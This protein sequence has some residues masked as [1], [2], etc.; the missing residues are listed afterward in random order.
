M[1]SSNWNSREIK[2]QKLGV[3]LSCCQSSVRSNHSILKEIQSTT[4]HIRKINQDKYNFLVEESIVKFKE[5]LNEFEVLTFDL[6]QYEALVNFQP[7]DFISRENKVDVLYLLIGLAVQRSKY[8][9]ILVTDVYT[10]IADF[11]T[12]DP[13][14]Y[15]ELLE[16]SMK[17]SREALKKSDRLTI[18][19][20]NYKSNLNK[21]LIN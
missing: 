8:I 7:S 16:G 5:I 3:I 1:N 13:D 14:I 17:A 4:D 2:D 11:Y 10:S 9:D 15:D 12:Y 20:S 18:L 21:N 19:L 6:V